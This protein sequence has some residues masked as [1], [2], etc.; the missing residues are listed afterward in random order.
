MKRSKIQEGDNVFVSFL[1]LLG[2]KHTKDFSNKYF[3]EHPHKYNLFGISKML[4]DYGIENVGARISDKGKDLFN[5]ETPFIAHTGVD[6]VVVY[7]ITQEEVHYIW[8][9]KKVSLPIPQLIEMWSGVVLLAETTPDSIEPDYKEHRK[10]EVFT[11][12]QKAILATACMVVC[13]MAYTTHS[14]FNNLGISL[15]L[16]I[17]LIGVYIGY[18]LVLKQMKIH[19]QYGDKICSLFSKSDCNDVL[20]SDA[21]KLWGVF[22]WSEIG[23]GYFVANVLLLLFA[24]QTV[25][26]LA[27]I[28]MIVLPYS[29]W[30]VWYQKM[31]A[32][33]WCPLC[34]IVQV[35]LWFI[36]IL[37]LLFGY[38]QLPELSFAGLVSCL[39]VGSTYLIAML[40]FNLMTPNF[41]SG[42]GMENIN[43][44]INSMKA[45]EDIF[46][47]LLSQ[48]PYYEV[49]KAD[50]QI[51]FGNP[52][53]NML[54]TILTNPF[55]N[56]C[57]KMHT[58]VEQLLEKTKDEICVQFIFS[59]FQPDLDYANQYLNA[60]YLEKDKET[61]LQ[62][63]NAWF[64]GGKMQRERFFENLQLDLSNPAVA[65]EFQKHETW[66]EKTQLRA[67]PT[68]L[69]NGYKLP[70]NYKI[71]DLRYL[72]PIK[73]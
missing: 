11:G 52:D 66:K 9:G 20:E 23:L 6:F 55:C 67:T 36:F 22:G 4:S 28:N 43:Q 15:L 59:S 51:L 54:I 69:V 38:I 64:A 70:N 65:S 3:N 45:N 17:N 60:I 35:L 68:I 19:S 1:T 33:Q 71:E 26:I 29:F 73:E 18:L 16:A 62:L 48:Q 31:R 30:S 46:K 40:I 25:S 39:F 12:V 7:Q 57:A 41:S 63:F 2:V 61:M 21:A 37:N 10:K 34:L 47:L 5:I 24:P 49:S 32:K 56:P 58:R 44:E 50:S 42:E 27:I 72:T 13:G 14:L 53:A 8:Q